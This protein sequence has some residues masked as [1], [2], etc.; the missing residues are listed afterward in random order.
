V[1]LAELP[2][3]KQVFA[4]VGRGASGD[5]FSAGS[6]SDVRKANLTVQLSHRSERKLTQGGVE[7]LIREKLQVLPGVRIA[8]GM[9]DNGEKLLLLLKGDDPVALTQAVHNV[10]RDLRNI[11]GLGNIT[12]TASLVRPEISIK[13][14]FA[15][16]ADLGV[17]AESVGD[18]VR[19]ATAGDYSVALAKLNLPQ[20]QVPIRVSMPDSARR[21]I[22]VLSRL[23]VHGKAG[24]VM[25]GN[26]AEI[27]MSSGSAQISRLDR[28]RNVVINVELNGRQLGDVFAEVNK[29][30][31]LSALPAGVKRAESGDVERMQE[32]FGSF[33]L[34]MLTGV[35]CVYIVL[36]L[37]FKD[38]LQPV[39]IL[40]ALPFAFGGAFVALLV[41]H[42]SFSMPSLI[43]LLMLMGIVTKNSILLVEYAIMARRE[44]GMSRAD[45]LIDA[46]N[47]RARPIVMTTIAM[48]AGMLPIA[49]GFG[50]D[51]SF[52]MPMATAVI[53]GLITSTVISLFVVP[54]VFTF[55]DD[56]TEKLKRLRRSEQEMGL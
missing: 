30:P 32:L 9:G 10:E 17:T 35:M 4:A 8:I 47:K 43:G 54:V 51:P 15:R 7:N 12:S 48:G 37:L 26:V 31:S 24:N 2:D 27:S 36:V 41:T 49:M 25:L 42:S 55:V 38:F 52:R 33:G 13:P 14:D 46:C 5:M 28:S 40:A 29:L 22:D 19:I 1:L 11:K 44:F 53:G 3:V 16:M 23:P 56:L 39:T 18:V 34:A 45:A 21:Q 20:R 6:E 50:A